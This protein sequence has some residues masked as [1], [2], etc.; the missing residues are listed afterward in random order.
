[1]KKL[2]LAFFTDCEYWFLTS[3]KSFIS[4]GLFNANAVRHR[5]FLCWSSSQV[6]GEPRAISVLSSTFLNRE[7]IINMVRK[8][9]FKKATRH[10]LLTG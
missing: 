7:C 4:R 10:P 8:A 3:L 1:L 5:M 6:W 9:L 2:A